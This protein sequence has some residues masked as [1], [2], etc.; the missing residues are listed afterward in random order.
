MALRCMDLLA[1]GGAPGGEERCISRRQ[2]LVDVGV[3][4]RHGVCHAVH[5]SKALV[6]RSNGDDPSWSAEAWA[7]QQR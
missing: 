2:V 4:S 1:M 3:H 7:A 5:S 6:M